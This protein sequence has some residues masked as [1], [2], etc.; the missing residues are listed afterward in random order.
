MT[1]DHLSKICGHQTYADSS[2]GCIKWLVEG[3]SGSRYSHH[4]QGVDTEKGDRIPIPE[5]QKLSADGYQQERLLRLIS[6]VQKW[7]CGHLFRRPQP[8]SGPL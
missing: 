6:E 2:G 1:C 8:L 7:E 3:R 4:R 5:P